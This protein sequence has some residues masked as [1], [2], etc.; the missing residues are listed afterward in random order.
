MARI[1]VYWDESHIWG[2]LALKALSAFGIPCRLVRATEIAQG[3]LAG[4][5]CA[6]L[7]VPGGQAR[8]KAELLG[9]AGVAAIREYVRAG[10]TYLGFCG[11]A[12]LG[13]TGQDGLDLCPWG[14][15]GFADRLH[16]F[17][18]GHMLVRLAGDDPL[19]PESLGSEALI[20]VW[21]PAQFSGGGKDVTVLARYERPG[22]DFWV[23]DLSL[24]LLSD[25]TLADWEDLYGIRVR[26]DF[27]EGRP[28]VVSGRLGSGRYIL[29]YSH[30]ETPGSAQANTWLAHILSM[31]L[32]ERL[33]AAKVPAWDVA[34]RPVAWRD[35]T[36]QA[37]RQ[38]L[39]S[40]IRTGEEHFLLF[41][42]NPWLLGWRR[43]IPGAG[44]GILYALVREAL[45]SQ[46]TEAARSF[47]RE[48]A[49][50]FARDMDLFRK[51]LKGYLLA[52][53]LAMTVLHSSPGSVPGRC[54]KE[55]RAALFG[56][57]PTSGGVY[58]S[59]LRPLE[60]L[61]FR[62]WQDKGADPFL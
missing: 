25:E 52:E 36:L 30:L 16:H 47:W 23:A 48:A 58:E 55:Q 8:K 45:A 43:G 31:V 37:A 50:C 33:R 7:I 26:P 15:Q 3:A 4:K 62:L 35:P 9:E 56:L 57:A 40:V 12:G 41:W 5:G 14:R 20:P 49:P 11:G 42:R 39:E 32:G 2:L 21:W 60:E 46:E 24:S 10:G 53:R 1:L 44:I 54:L 38:A 13:L 19:V 51:G 28:C 27:L 34:G 59:L 17:L 6:V 18:S 61:G 22:P 29:S